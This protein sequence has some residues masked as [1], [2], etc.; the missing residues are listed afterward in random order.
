MTVLRAGVSFLT[1][2]RAQSV[3]CLLSANVMTPLNLLMV[4]ILTVSLILSGH[5]MWLVESK[6]NPTMFPPTYLDGVDDGIWWSVVTL[7]TV[8]AYA[9]L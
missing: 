2:L 9:S 6:Y 8:H 4:G 7:A 3:A 1:T 5:L